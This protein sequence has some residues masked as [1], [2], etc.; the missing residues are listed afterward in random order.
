MMRENESDH[1]GQPAEYVSPWA[2]RADSP[3]AEDEYPPGAQDDAFSPYYADSHQ[4]MPSS[5]GSN[6]TIPVPG[7]GF[8]G[9]GHPDQPDPDWGTPNPDWGNWLPDDGYGM[10]APPR[11]RRG[12]PLIYLVVAVVAACVGAGATVAL[13]RTGAAAPAGVSSRDNAGSRH[14]TGTGGGATSSLNPAAVEGK[15]EPGLVDIVSTLKYNSETAEGTG[16]V[17]SSDGLV[18]TNNHVID[19]STSIA[20]TL[21]GSGRTYQA[22]VLGYDASGDVALLKLEGATDLPVVKLGNSGQV[23]LGTPVLALGNAQGRGGV[24]PAEGIINGLDRSINASDEGSGGTESLHHMLQTN[25]KIQQGDSGGALADN[26]GQVIGMIT[27]ANT[28][29]GASGGTLGFAIPINTA[30]T[31][32]RQVAAGTASSNVYIGTPGFLGVVLANSTSPDP[33]KQDTDEQNWLA[34]NGGGGGPGGGFRGTC[35]ENNTEL[36]APTTVAPAGSGVLIVADFCGTAVAESGLVPGD[37]IT[38]VNGRAVATPNSL[39]SLT[40]NYHPGTTVQ[41]GWT[42]AD[43]AR[44]TTPVTLGPGPVR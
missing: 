20:A 16:M 30:L 37:V 1:E 23:S 18:L 31:I 13:N 25:A 33:R 12:R 32:A 15:V 36:T 10:P 40:V 22:K 24:T 44:H 17:L 9:P 19:Q 43:G 38:S 2:P 26:A 3:G 21:V 28:T 8:S 27:A 5:P 34:Q 35:I 4:G 29:S 42:A 14:A 7:P 39:R 11:P 6:P 41:I